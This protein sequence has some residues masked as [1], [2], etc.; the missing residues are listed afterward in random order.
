MLRH[1]DLP[2][3]FATLHQKAVNETHAM[4]T[5]KHIPFPNSN[6]SQFSVHGNRTSLKSGILSQI[7]IHHHPFSSESQSDKEH[8]KFGTRSNAMQRQQQLL[9]LAKL[10]L[11]FLQ[12]KVPASTISN[13]Q[14][15]NTI[16]FRHSSSPQ[17][18]ISP[19]IL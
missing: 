11:A 5:V 13:K 17:Q 18:F 8:V 15:L 2:I 7:N 10:K 6:P 14:P 9:E 19:H 1:R 12:R 3:T 4:N 16:R